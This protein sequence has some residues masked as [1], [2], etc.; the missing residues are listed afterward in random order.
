MLLAR[1]GNNINVYNKYLRD[2]AHLYKLIKRKG[3]YC[4]VYLKYIASVVWEYNEKWDIQFEFNHNEVCNLRRF[5]LIVP[6][7]CSVY[8]G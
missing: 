6:V 3:S 8:S 5:R 1:I 7:S 4:F 2:I